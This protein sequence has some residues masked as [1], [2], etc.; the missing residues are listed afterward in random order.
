MSSFEVFFIITNHLV[1]YHRVRELLRLMKTSVTVWR[2]SLIVVK[3]ISS[4]LDVFI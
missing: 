4:T 1:Q 2:N 3:L